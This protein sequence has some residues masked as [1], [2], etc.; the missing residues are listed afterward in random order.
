[1]CTTAS[2]I[3]FFP[4]E[5]TEKEATEEVVGETTSDAVDLAGT[6]QNSTE[7]ESENTISL[8]EKEGDVQQRNLTTG[9]INSTSEETENA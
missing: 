2:S 9:E 3:N 4:T 1:M 6:G 8:S 5:T 7:S